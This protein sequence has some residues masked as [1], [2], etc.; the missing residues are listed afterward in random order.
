MGNTIS[1]RQVNQN[2]YRLA[3][4]ELA[5]GVYLVNIKTANGSVTKKVIVRHE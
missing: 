4:D 2:N 5:N 1:Q 3:T